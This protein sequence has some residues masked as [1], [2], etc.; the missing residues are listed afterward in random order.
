MRAKFRQ[1]QRSKDMR[2]EAQA[3]IARGEDR[4]QGGKGWNRSALGYG[5]ADGA[6]VESIQKPRLQ[7]DDVIPCCHAIQIELIGHQ[8]FRYRARGTPFS[9]IQRL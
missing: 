5:K 8:N 1:R 2:G 7:D 6:G 4:T 3:D 9:S